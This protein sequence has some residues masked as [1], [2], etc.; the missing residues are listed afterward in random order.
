MVHPASVFR[1][2]RVPVSG[3]NELNDAAC[4][5][6][7]DLCVVGAGPAGLAVAFGAHDRGMR[8][9]VLEAGG[10]SPSFA[11]RPMLA[12]EISDPATHAPVEVATTPALGGTSHLWGGRAVPF[13]PVDFARPSIHTKGAPEWPLD[14]ADLLPWWEE[15]ARF[16][17]SHAVF[18][19]PAPG[20]FANL[21]SHTA[22]L[23]ESWGPELN[24]ARRWRDRLNGED[25]P[26]I[27]CSVRAIGFET[28][29]SSVGAVRVR[30]EERAQRVLARNVVLA[31]GGLGTMKLLLNAE[32]TAPGLLAGAQH[33]GVGYMGHLTGSIADLVADDPDDIGA[34]GCRPGTDGIVTRRRIM[35]SAD[36]QAAHDMGNVA[37]WLDNPPLGDA[38]HG[39][40]TLSA[41][42][43]LLRQASVGRRLVSDGLRALALR[44]A[45]GP[46]TPHLVNVLRQ[47][48][49]T[50][51]G[52]AQAVAARLTDRY[53]R[54]EHLI[55][56]KDGG[57][58]LHYH[59]EQ[60]FDSANRVTLS[61]TKD[62]AGLYRLKIEY[63]FSDKDC[64]SVLRAHEMLDKDL[65][66]AGAGSLRFIH[67]REACLDR[68]RELASDGYHQIGGTRMSRSPS[69]GVVDPDCRVHGLDNLWVAS[70]STFPSAGQANPTLTIV[71]LAC[72]LA[73][74][75][76]TVQDR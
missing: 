1:E 49:S 24:M 14:Y 47:P 53:R 11:S 18:D 7:Y 64:I 70:S 50:M 45:D 40:G 4:D 71:A 62:P 57:W 58:R 34:F 6:T 31:C 66:S 16:L 59:A 28:D 17:G 61:E 68:I 10:Q 9:L 74:H 13:D 23:S 33:L 38:A 15:A 42:Y 76:G 51:T 36:L 48:V 41:K 32:R 39:S 72:R 46:L 27:V 30:L 54:P 3:V 43:L 35:P 65:R 26:K 2:C 8:V 5:V 12:A 20:Q 44:G 22:T 52:L 25:G 19:S 67:E 37:F 29:R 75:I 55:P 21:R 73:A 56:A 63:G 60:R 69:D